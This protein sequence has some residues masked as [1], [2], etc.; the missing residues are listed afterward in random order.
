ML[1]PEKSGALR[2]LLRLCSCQKDTR[3]FTSVLLAV[4]A[5]SEVAIETKV[6]ETTVL[7]KQFCQTFD[8]DGWL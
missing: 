6:H 8:A 7:Q 2:S 5:A 1:P 3:I 4:T